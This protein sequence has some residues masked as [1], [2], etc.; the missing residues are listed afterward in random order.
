MRYFSVKNY[1]RFQHYKGRGRPVWI[2]LHRV[3]LDN[4]EFAQLPDTGKAHLML[5]WLLASQLDN[6]LPYSPKWIAKRIGASSPV[7]LQELERAGFIE[8]KGESEDPNQTTPE[9]SE[10]HARV[11]SQ[12]TLECSSKSRSYIVSSPLV[13]SDLP[14]PD[15]DPDPSP[16]AVAARRSKTPEVLSD[17]AEFW[18]AYPRRD[19][20]QAAAQ[21]W[22]R[23]TPE[24]RRLAAEDVPKR[25]LANWAGRE[26]QHIPQAAT[27]LNQRRWLD[28][29]EP[30]A[31]LPD[32]RPKL[33]PGMERL[34]RAYMEARSRERN[35]SN[36][37]DD[38][39]QGDVVETTGRPIRSG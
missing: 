3:L 14:N 32:G 1:E 39:S 35:G 28:G 20:K 22:S 9:Q 31:R 15:P 27:Y 18:R 10:K 29:I 11:V 7:D 17:F 16:P 33:S 23:L 34:G 36:P 26:L 21:S 19:A 30:R 12:S 4:F 37:A 38:T 13:S 25:M 6:K 2:K 24:E 5:V 8:V